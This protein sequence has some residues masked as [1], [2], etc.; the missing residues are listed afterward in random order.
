M[1][2][3]AHQSGGFLGDETTRMNPSRP[4]PRPERRYWPHNRRV[5]A[6]PT[7]LSPGLDLTRSRASIAWGSVD[8]PLRS[9]SHDRSRLCVWRT[10]VLGRPQACC[11][12]GRARSEPT[13]EDL[14][15][16]IEEQDQ[17]I[18]VSSAS[19]RSRKADKTAASS[20]ATVKASERRFSTPVCRRP[21]PVKLRAWCTSTAGSC[22]RD[23]MTSPI[24]AGNRVRPIIEGTVGGI[25]DFRFTPDFG[26]GK[27]VISDAYVTARFKPGSRSR[28]SSSRR[29][30]LE[31]LQSAN[32]IRFVSRASDQPGA[33]PRPGAAGGRQPARRPRVVRRGLAQRQQRWLEQRC[34]RRT[35]T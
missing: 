31:R 26:Q 13:I 5:R 20:T 34:L 9:T 10:A 30:G 6:G 16:R 7:D 24:S 8:I 25:Y 35:S 27:T 33:E 15:K 1:R 3:W 22:W 12:V 29:C 19:S 14:L 18:L 2:L 32:D 28:R 17:K 4:R 11:P 23:D 21:E